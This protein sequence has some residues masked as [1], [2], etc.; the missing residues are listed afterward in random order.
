VILDEEMTKTSRL[1]FYSGKKEVK[2][3]QGSVINCD[4]IF[5]CGGAFINSKSYENSDFFKNKLADRKRIIVNSKLQVEGSENIFAIGDC[6]FAGSAMAFIAGL[7][8]EVCAHN[9]IKHYNHQKNAMKDFAPP[10]PAMFVP[11][12]THQG[13]SQLPTK[14]GYV[15]GATVT[16]KIKGETLFVGKYWKDLGF[17]GVPDQLVIPNKNNVIQEAVKDVKEDDKNEKEDLD[18][19]KEEKGQKDVVFENVEVEDKY[20]RFTLLMEQTNKM[21]NKEVQKLFEGLDVNQPKEDDKY[22]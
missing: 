4:L 3:E 21:T 15:V 22:T 11:L 19:K 18:E 2:T 16:S 7:E 12:G 8:A 1:R 17:K 20:R 14:N 10:A 6:A 9:I 13:A 5:F